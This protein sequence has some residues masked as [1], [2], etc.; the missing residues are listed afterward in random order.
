[1]RNGADGT[2]SDQRVA[3]CIVYG[4]PSCSLAA[5]NAMLG[6]HTRLT[7]GVDY[8]SRFCRAV[9]AFT[10]ATALVGVLQGLM[11]CTTARA[12]LCPDVN[13]PPD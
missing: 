2:G 9:R 12:R 10:T 1:V 3:R 13:K 7:P 4:V 6:A 5:I 11:L 8:L